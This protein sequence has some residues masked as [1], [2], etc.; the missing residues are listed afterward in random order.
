MTNKTIKQLLTQLNGT[1]NKYDIFLRPVSATVDS[2]KVWLTR[3]KMTDDVIV[4]DQPYKFYFI[5]NREGK[6]QQRYA[7]C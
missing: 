5:K 1:G 2:G 3:P 7:E 4:D 6:I